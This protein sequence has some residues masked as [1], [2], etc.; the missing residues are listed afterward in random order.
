MQ[1]AIAVLAALATL[2]IATA[3]ASDSRCRQGI[4]LQT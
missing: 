1:S 3:P 4:S 2:M